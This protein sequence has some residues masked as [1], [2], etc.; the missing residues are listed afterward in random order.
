[1]T[2]CDL[3]GEILKQDPLNHVSKKL[4]NNL[5]SNSL[6]S[7]TAYKNSPSAFTTY[8]ELYLL[9]YQGNVQLY[10]QEAFHYFSKRSSH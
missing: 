8:T 9:W 3:C 4:G 7:D 1:M 6:T 2:T 10:E 5:K